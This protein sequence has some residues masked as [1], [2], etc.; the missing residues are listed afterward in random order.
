[1]DIYKHKL[2]KTINN[3]KVKKEKTILNAQ[4]VKLTIKNIFFLWTIPSPESICI[5]CAIL[6]HNCKNIK[7]CGLYILKPPGIS[8]Y[9]HAR[10]VTKQYFKIKCFYFLQEIEIQSSPNYIILK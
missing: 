5:D 7:Y 3:K 9:S 4:T 2:K 1:M 6:K 10:Q 8:F